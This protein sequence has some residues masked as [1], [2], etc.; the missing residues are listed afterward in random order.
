MKHGSKHTSVA[1]N[2]AYRVQ[3]NNRSPCLGNFVHKPH[4]IAH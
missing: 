3:Y 4:F 2:T 1:I